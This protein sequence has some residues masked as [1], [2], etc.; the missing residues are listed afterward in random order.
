MA[1]EH[2]IDGGFRHVLDAITDG[3]YVACPDRT[4]FYWS[5]G[6]ERGGRDDF[7]VAGNGSGG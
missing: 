7:A 4:I 3:V 1:A 5:A 6:A 2:G